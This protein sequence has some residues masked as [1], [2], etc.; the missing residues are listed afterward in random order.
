VKKDRAAAMSLTDRFTKIIRTAGLPGR[1]VVLV[2][3]AIPTSGIG[4]SHR[5]GR[6]GPM[7]SAPDRR[8]PL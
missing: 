5:A 3:S 8:L 1:A 4:R 6:G 7:S 2:L